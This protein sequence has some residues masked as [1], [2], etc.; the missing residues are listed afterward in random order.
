MK[1]LIFILVLVTALT[2]HA[3]RGLGSACT[4]DGQCLSKECKGFRCIPQSR[5]NKLGAGC[6]VD[7]QCLS[8]ECKGL[9]CVSINNNKGVGNLLLNALLNKFESI[10][11][12][13][14]K[15]GFRID[16][17]NVELGL[18]PKVTVDITRIKALTRS[19]QVKVMREYKGR[20][21]V[22]AILKALFTAHSLKFDSYVVNKS[23]L[24]LVPP[25][26]TL[27]LDKK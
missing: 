19:E 21:Y 22:S 15:A 7:G 24:Q 11:P 3:K 12:I 5:L 10:S 27:S 1:S 23:T 4:F 8:G 9:K 16:G 6:A 2:S 25:K 14:E 18:K 26:V 17:L 13:I 20:I